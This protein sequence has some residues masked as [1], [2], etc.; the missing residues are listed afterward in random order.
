MD[1]VMNIKLHKVTV[2]DLADGYED[3]Q[4]GGV[5]GYGGRLDIRPPFQREF[6]YDEK[7]RSAVIDTINRGFPLNV[8]YWAKRVAGDFEIIDGQQ[9]TISICQYVAGDFSVND[10]YFHN[11]TD[12]KKAHILDYELMVYVC[13]GTE[14]EKLEWFRII[15]I[16]G[17][18]LTEQELR[19]AV[20]AGPWLSN[21]KRYFSRNGCPAFRIGSDY[22]KGS[23]IRQE[24]L[25]TAI[26]WASAGDI[27]GYM[28]RHQQDSDAEPLW[29]HYRAVI[30]WI[31]A[32][33]TV[34]RRDMKKVDWGPLYDGHKYDVLDADKIEAETQRLL[35]DEDVMRHAGIYPYL[36][37]G[38]E[39]HLNVR[40]FSPQIKQRVYER[41]DRRCAECNEEFKLKDMEADHIEPWSAGGRTAENNCQM[42]CKEHNRRKAAT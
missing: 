14:S 2:G 16:A 10:L 7:Q 42:L 25:E 23:P 17:E 24:L 3:K 39:K 38:D 32:T 11:L 21:A 6:V 8:M 27:E 9:R 41:Q 12:D 20:Y 40:A 13:D 5:V 1:Y 30:D 29:A 31:E 34:K 26:R 37:T 15:N 4:E 19:N 33:F 28:G 36:L 22:V 35:A 18:K